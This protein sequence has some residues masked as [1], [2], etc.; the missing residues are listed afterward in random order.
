MF[1][2][3]LLQGE[4][5]PNSGNPGRVALTLA[6][7]VVPLVIISGLIVYYFHTG[8]QLTN[9]TKQ[10]SHL[11][12]QVAGLAELRNKQEKLEEHVGESNRCLQEVAEVLPRCVQWSGIL[13]SIAQNIPDTLVV[14]EL[15]VK[16]GQV[17]IEAPRK[18]NPKKK[19][20]ISVPQRTLRVSVYDHSS[21][22]ND[23][24]VLLLIQRLCSEPLFMS[25]MDDIRLRAHQLDRVG[26]QRLNR[27]EIDCVLKTPI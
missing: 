18:D 22:G 13:Q 23:E 24:A 1:T 7:I 5:R 4:G 27:Y 6:A 12:V 14:R 17:H 2:I 8:K 11:K 20:T 26:N 10:L 15:E 3:D 9:G 21:P 25:Q 16:R 19:I